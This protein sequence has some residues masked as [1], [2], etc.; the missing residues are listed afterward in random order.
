MFVTCALSLAWPFGGQPAAPR[1]PSVAPLATPVGASIATVV[2]AL[3]AIEPARNARHPDSLDRAAAIIADG[4]TAA[5]LRPRSQTFEVDGYR[6]QNVIALLGTGRRPRIVVGAHYDVA[7]D[8]PGADD[9][10]SGVAALL[11]VAGR[12]AD[13]RF[14]IDVELVAFTL[15]EPPYFRTPWAAPVTRLPCS[16]SAS[17]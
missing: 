5:G 2:D 3:T 8:Q 7:G 1:T 9:N 16:R 11:H 13:K 17:R 12:L 6:Y 10:A 14:P 4:F 15:E